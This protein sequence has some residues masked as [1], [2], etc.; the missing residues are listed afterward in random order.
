[1]TDMAAVMLRF[2]QDTFPWGGFGT[3]AYEHIAGYPLDNQFVGGGF[4]NRVMVAVD[5]LRV[6]CHLVGWA[7]LGTFV[8]FDLARPE[9]LDRLQATIEDML[10]T[11]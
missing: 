2:L 6:C 4:K 11:K 7:G 1:M 8:E 5:E 9:S 10:E 3:T